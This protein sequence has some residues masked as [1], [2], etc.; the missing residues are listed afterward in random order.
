MFNLGRVGLRAAGK[1]AASVS[2]LNGVLSGHGWGRGILGL[3]ERREARRG[4]HAFAIAIDVWSAILEG[5]GGTAM[6]ALGRSN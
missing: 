3:R 5:S 1:A 2:L 6:R 4:G